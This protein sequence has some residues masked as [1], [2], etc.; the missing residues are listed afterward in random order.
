MPCPL[1]PAAAYKLFWLHNNDDRSSYH[2]KGWVNYV[3]YLLTLVY[4]LTHVQLHSHPKIPPLLFGFP[5]T[6]RV[7]LLSDIGLKITKNNDDIELFSDMILP[8]K[9]RLKKSV[10]KMR[11]N[12]RYK[13]RLTWNEEI[14]RS[15]TP[16]LGA[17]SSADVS[18]HN[19]FAHKL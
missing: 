9:K 3:T 2:F 1:H 6:F 16:E 12:A 4:T 10:L 14:L 8:C 11:K 7:R 5:S 18:L 13:G 15:R 19:N 17:E